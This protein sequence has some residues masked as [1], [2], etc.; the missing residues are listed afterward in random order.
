MIEE[1]CRYISNCLN[2][3]IN[4]IIELKA[5][6]FVRLSYLPIVDRR[7][8]DTHSKFMVMFFYSNECISPPDAGWNVAQCDPKAGYNNWNLLF[9]FRDNYH[10]KEFK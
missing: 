2:F 10:F 5:Q 9:H 7:V 6:F 1:I 8:D 3:I 4:W